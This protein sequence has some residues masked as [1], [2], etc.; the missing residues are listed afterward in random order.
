MTTDLGA[1]RSRHW[2]RFMLRWLW[3]TKGLLLTL[4]GIVVFWIVIIEVRN[5]HPIVLP[6]PSSVIDALTGNLGKY[7]RAGF[8]TF[9]EMILGFIGGGA[10]GFFSAI[11]I[12][13]S[14]FLRRSLYPLLLGFRIVPKV[15]FVP[16]FLVWFGIGIG[17]KVALASFAIFFLVLVQ[18]LLGL[19]SVAPEMVELG[20][21][22]RM[23]ELLLL[24]RIRLPAALP[25]IMVG[26][27]L[28]ITYALTNVVVAEMV[29]ATNGLGFLVVE[30]SSF[31]K[32]DE[33]IA[34][35]F[36]VAFIGLIVFAAGLW[37][38]R[39]TTFWYTED[40]T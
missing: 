3:N 28:G 20:R 21:S 1:R 2:F 23:S 27:K 34:A 26:V 33:M 11:G 9:Y 4:T 5:F 35:I 12:F 13:Y 29:V 15:A 30:A 6:H 40:G 39:R 14:P 8:I 38:E 7:A 19:T 24:R 10:L 36:V 37:V 31:I 16:L 32:T 25:A 22:L 17:V 18:T